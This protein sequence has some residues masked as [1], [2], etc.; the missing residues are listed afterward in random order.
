[1]VHAPPGSQFL[2]TIQEQEPYESLQEDVHPK[3]AVEV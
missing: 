3:P 2:Q 1:V